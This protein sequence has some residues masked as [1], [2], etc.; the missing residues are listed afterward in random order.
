MYAKAVEQLGNEQAPVRLGGLYALERLAQD[1]PALRQTIV[2]VICAY[3]RMPYALPANAS[4]PTTCATTPLPYA[5]ELSHVRLAPAA[6]GVLRVWPPAW[7]VEAAADGWQ[8]VRSAP[9]LEEG[10][11]GGGPGAGPADLAGP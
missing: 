11:A 2:D 4:W 3:L 7:R 6:D 9:V 5:A 1:T 8:A 10:R